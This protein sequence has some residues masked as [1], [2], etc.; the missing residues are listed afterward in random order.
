MYSV[1]W[2]AFQ[3]TMVVKSDSFSYHSLPV[4]SWPALYLMHYSVYSQTCLGDYLFLL[5]L[6]FMQTLTKALGLYQH[7]CMRCAA[8]AWLVNQ[9][10]AVRVFL[11]KCPVRVVCWKINTYSFQSFQVKGS[12]IYSLHIVTTL[13][14]LCIYQMCP[15]NPP[16]LVY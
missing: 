5:V 8:F 2:D 3:H 14:H 10:A 4:S 1:L 15:H 7:D 11:L 6:C 9:T 13:F 12:D 16:M